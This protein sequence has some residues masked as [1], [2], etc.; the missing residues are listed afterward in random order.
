MSQTLAVAVSLFAVMLLL[1]SAVA[2][3]QEAAPQAPPLPPGVTQ[4]SRHSITAQPNPDGSFKLN[5]QPAAQQNA[6]SISVPV[7]QQ[8]PQTQKP[9][10]IPALLPPRSWTTCPTFTPA[11]MSRPVYQNL[12]AVNLYIDI[13][14][15]YEH[16]IQCHDREGDCAASASGSRLPQFDS[17]KY[18]Q[19]LKDAYN[20]Y[21]KELRRDALTALYRGRLKIAF[22]SLLP[23]DQSCQPPEPILL[24]DNHLYTVDTSTNEITLT[25]KVTVVE[26]TTLPLVV[27]STSYFRADPR[28]TEYDLSI[29]F[30][31][32]FPLDIPEPEATRILTDFA[33]RT[34]GDRPIASYVHEG[35]Q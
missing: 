12:Q 33:D 31:T 9:P 6:P 29:P 5:I 30:S 32:A 35:S 18:I 3:A 2:P 24:T 13:P 14:S 27:L 21:P 22:S 8:A 19:G 16:A 11:N 25:V 4:D 1:S 7:A 23:R 15:N 10:A 28:H 17:A 20:R 34:A 26:T